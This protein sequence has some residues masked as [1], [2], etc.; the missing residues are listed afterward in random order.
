MPDQASKEKNFSWKRIVFLIYP[1][2]LA[3]YPILA[4]RNHN[5]EYVDFASILRPLILIAVGTLAIQIVVLLLIR[6]LEKT[7]LIVS[8]V[9]LLFL[10]YGHIYNQIGSKL[11]LLVHHRY[12]AGG[13]ILLVIMAVILIFKKDRF[14]RI[15]TQFMGI[16]SLVLI[17]MVLFDSIRYDLQV[18][19]AEAAVTSSTAQQTNITNQTA[20]PDFYLILLD[21]HPRRRAQIPVWI[22]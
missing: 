19:R 7:N 2:L 17:A 22:R 11:G 21:G 10:S 20:L 12:L 18:Y 14:A 9:V 1:Y 16:A 13:E 3:F 4:L 15:L 8:L 5:F 6:N